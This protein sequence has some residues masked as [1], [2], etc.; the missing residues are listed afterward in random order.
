[1]EILHVHVNV[2]NST[3]STMYAVVKAR[4]RWI[5]NKF[6]ELQIDYREINKGMKNKN[7]STFD[8][9]CYHD[10]CFIFYID[11]EQ[12]IYRAET[13]FSSNNLN[14][15]F[16]FISWTVFSYSRNISLFLLID[17][18]TC[19]IFLSFGNEIAVKLLLYR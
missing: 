10:E 13:Y 19:F 5:I 16:L 6:P 2:W 3:K 9:C 15:K 1:M 7:V 18:C 12:L 8:F 14:H 11:C 17:Q 4:A